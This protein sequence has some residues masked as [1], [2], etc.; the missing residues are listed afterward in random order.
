M[1]VWFTDDTNH[2]IALTDDGKVHLCDDCPCNA[3]AGYASSYFV[4]DTSFVW[5]ATVTS[6]TYTDI[7]L[8]QPAC[9]ASFYAAR[10]DWCFWT[11]IANEV[12]VRYVINVNPGV[13][14]S[15]FW[16]T[17]FCP[18]SHERA[19]GSAIVGSWFEYNIS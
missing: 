17:S 6:I 11:G 12:A 2:K 8:V 18:P 19:I 15:V 13:G 5:T 7:L 16:N 14:G 10:A 4:Q 1:K 9:M 3:C